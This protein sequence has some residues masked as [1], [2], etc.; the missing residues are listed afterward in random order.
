MQVRVL[1]YYESAGQVLAFHVNWLRSR[2]YKDAILHLPHDGA[3]ATTLVQR[4]GD[5][6]PA[7]TR[8]GS[9]TSARMTCV[10]SVSGLSMI[11]RAM[12]PTRS[13]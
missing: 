4:G 6:K 12:P 5:G 1:D 9:V 2:G 3:G 11:G 8:L 13:G 10:T 7:V